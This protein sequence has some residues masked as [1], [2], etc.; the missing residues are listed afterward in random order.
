MPFPPK[1]AVVRPA[2]GRSFAVS[3]KMP[4]RTTRRARGKPDSRLCETLVAVPMPCSEASYG[5]GRDGRRR[6][7]ETAAGRERPP[8]NG[9]DLHSRAF[10]RGR[11]RELSLQEGRAVPWGRGSLRAPEFRMVLRRSR[12]L[13]R[14]LSETHCGARSGVAAR[15]EVW[16]DPPPFP[17]PI[18]QTL[19]S[20]TRLA[21]SDHILAVHFTCQKMIV[22]GCRRAAVAGACPGAFR[23]TGLLR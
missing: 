11:S 13:R 14:C 23:E 6:K 7:A 12:C 3:G 5:F 2:W 16:P 9:P 10:R 18:S 20:R 22:V 15:P 8:E 4:Q 1:G 21:R 19:P 17:R